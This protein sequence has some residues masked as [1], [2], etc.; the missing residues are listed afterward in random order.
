MWGHIGAMLGHLESMLSHLGAMLGN[1]GAILS[2]L[3][4]ILS[5]LG[6]ML[7]QLSKNIEKS[8]IFIDFSSFLSPPLRAETSRNPGAPFGGSVL[9]RVKLADCNFNQLKAAFRHLGNISP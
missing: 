7:S 3:E 2:H 8:L 1:F 4:A 6:A 9:I 5:H